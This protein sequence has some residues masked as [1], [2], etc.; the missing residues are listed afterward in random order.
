M[1]RA[2]WEGVCRA[3]R[4]GA[5][6]PGSKRSSGAKRASGGWPRRN[7]RKSFIGPNHQAGACAARAD[8]ALPPG[9]SPEASTR[10]PGRWNGRVAGAGSQPGA[11]GGRKVVLPLLTGGNQGPTSG[12]RRRLERAARES[13]PG[14]DSLAHASTPIST[15]GL[16]RQ[17][18]RGSQGRLVCVHEMGTAGCASPGAGWPAAREA[19]QSG[20][21]REKCAAM[22]ARTRREVG[23]GVGQE[24]HG[25]GSGCKAGPTTRRRGGAA[26]L[27]PRASLTPRRRRRRRGRPPGPLQSTARR[28]GARRT[29]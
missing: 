3:A 7:S 28:P 27:P 17:P 1:S 16:T 2:I 29:A 19:E 26:M 4:C 23:S 21:A 13:R 12:R 18:R 6:R 14:G 5:A 20:K 15:A 8:P 9:R 10:P 22:Q 24:L 25:S 11:Q